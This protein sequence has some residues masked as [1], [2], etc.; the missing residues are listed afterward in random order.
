MTVL[1]EYGVRSC[2]Y[3]HLHGRACENAVNGVREGIY[4]RL[5][6]GD[7]VQFDPVPVA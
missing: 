5:I 2:Y 6:S 3:G 7:Y 1:Q 4:Y